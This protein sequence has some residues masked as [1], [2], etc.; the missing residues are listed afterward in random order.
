MLAGG[1]REGRRPPEDEAGLRPPFIPPA[2]QGPEGDALHGERREHGGADAEHHDGKQRRA[3]PEPEQHPAARQRHDLAM[4]EVDQP[5]DGEDDGQPQREQ[6]VDAAE[7]EGVD[8]LLEDDV[9]RV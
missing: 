3:E 7:A 8:V 1:L 5:D 9:H 6:R 4:G 2:A